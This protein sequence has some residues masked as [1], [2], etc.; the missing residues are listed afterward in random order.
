MRVPHR[1]ASSDGAGEV[2]THGTPAR[3]ARSIATSR[4][5]QV[6]L[7]SACAFLPV[8]LYAL[9]ARKRLSFTDGTPM[10]NLFLSMLERA[11]VEHDRFG[12]STGVLTGL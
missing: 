9:W 3:R 6:G 2:K 10:C 5:F 11:G 7:R 8:L 4:A 12:D 1:N